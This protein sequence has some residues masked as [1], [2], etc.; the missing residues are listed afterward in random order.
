MIITKNY[1]DIDEKLYNN[2]FISNFGNLYKDK[3]NQIVFIKGFENGGEITFLNYYCFNILLN[4]TKNQNTIFHTL[5]DNFFN[6]LSIHKNKLIF[7]GF[8]NENH[9]SFTLTKMIYLHPHK[10]LGIFVRKKILSKFGEH[11]ITIVLNKKQYE[12]NITVFTLQ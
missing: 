1:F 7:S 2:L 12:E 6:D 8:V 9:T 4:N 3:Q 10:K 5:D 11:D